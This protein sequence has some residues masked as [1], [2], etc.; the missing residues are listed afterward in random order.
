M[1]F[2]LALDEN[3]DFFLI[4]NETYKRVMEINRFSVEKRVISCK[5]FS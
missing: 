1:L 2:Y 3:R 5:Y 4:I